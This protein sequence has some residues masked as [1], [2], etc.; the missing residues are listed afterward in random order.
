[1][2]GWEAINCKGIVIQCRDK[3]SIEMVERTHYK[4]GI[5]CCC[6]GNPPAIQRMW[7]WLLFFF[8]CLLMSTWWRISLA[9]SVS[10]L[11]LS[12]DLVGQIESLFILITLNGHPRERHP[13]GLILES[14]DDLLDDKFNS[15]CPPFQCC[16]AK[17]WQSISQLWMG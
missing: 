17:K 1:M 15:S 3:G 12:A 2:W 8:S 9:L 5:E 16:S 13:G 7:C 6:G 10:G 11:L 4:N 14:E